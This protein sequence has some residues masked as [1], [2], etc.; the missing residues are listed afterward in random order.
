MDLGA[1]KGLILT[2]VLTKGIVL[3]NKS[4]ELRTKLTLAMLA[5]QEDELP[6]FAAFSRPAQGGFSM[7]RDLVLVKLESLAD[8]STVSS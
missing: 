8:A 5:F 4:P 6:C 2:Q 3:C 1:A 7:D